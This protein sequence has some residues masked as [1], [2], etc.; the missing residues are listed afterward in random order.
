MQ[1]MP[2]IVARRNGRVVGFL[3]TSTRT[4]NAD[5]LIVQAMFVAYHGSEDAYVYNGILS[6]LCALPKFCIVGVTLEY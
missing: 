3:M 5:V 2:L 4:M 6:V 1:A